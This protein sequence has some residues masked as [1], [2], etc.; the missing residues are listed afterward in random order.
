YDV[1]VVQGAQG[2]TYDELDCSSGTCSITDIVATLTVDFPG[3]KGVHTYVKTND[4]TSSSFT[5]GD[6][7]NTTYKDDTTTLTVLKAF[8]DVKVV[9]GAQWRG[10]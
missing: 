7:T 3:I 6:V 4:G 5:G 9:E 1:K 10:C 2:N 8:Y